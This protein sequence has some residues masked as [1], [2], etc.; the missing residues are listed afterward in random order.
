VKAFHLL[1]RFLYI[2][3]DFYH[4][5]MMS[6][7]DGPVRSTKR[8]MK[9]FGSFANAP[10][11]PL[12][13]DKQFPPFVNFDQESMYSR[14]LHLLHSANLAYFSPVP[15]YDA[16]SHPFVFSK[17]DFVHLPSLPRYKKHGDPKHGDLPPNALV[18]VFFSLNTYASTRPPPTPSSVKVSA[19]S[20][21]QAPSRHDNTF[22]PGQGSSARGGDAAGCGISHLSLNLQFI[23]YHGLI[24]DD[25]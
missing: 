4:V 22:S 11:A 23:L 25:D 13:F 20:E 14:F 17:E 21:S 19:R 9:A 7:T 12:W 3:L 24:P 10:P 1:V 15:I 16:H 2:A 5:L 6:L 8:N 18:T